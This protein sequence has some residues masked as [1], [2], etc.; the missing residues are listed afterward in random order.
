MPLKMILKKGLHVLTIGLIL[1]TSLISCK[2][3][4]ENTPY[5]LSETGLVNASGDYIPYSDTERTIDYTCFSSNDLVELKV[6][7]GRY[8][9]KGGDDF[10]L[11]TYQ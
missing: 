9:R 10:P 5:V 1:N 7:I 11:E 3:N 2:F 6:Q 4:W 8:C